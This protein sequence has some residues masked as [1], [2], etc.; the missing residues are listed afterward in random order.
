MS[1]AKGP[2]TRFDPSGNTEAF[3]AFARTTAPEMPAAKRSS[4]AVIVGA[5]AAV[6]IVAVVVI[7]LVS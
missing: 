6:I 5:A 4:L 3:Q 2:E 1:E 7:L